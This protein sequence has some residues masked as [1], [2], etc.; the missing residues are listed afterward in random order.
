MKKLL[1]SVIFVM[2][3]VL[4]ALAVET[5]AEENLARLRQNLKV[6][7]NTVDSLSIIYDIFDNLPV[8]EQY[9]MAE[10]IYAMAYRCNDY[11]GILDM[12]RD[13]TR[14]SNDYN[15][16]ALC[17]ERA[18]KVPDSELKKATVS[19]IKIQ[20]SRIAVADSVYNDD[21]K[22][23]K[24]IADLSVEY[25]QIRQ[26]ESN[27]LSRIELLFSICF[28]LRKSAPGTA[29]NDRLIEL[30]GLVERLPDGYEALKNLYYNEC[31]S[32]FM[33]IGRYPQAISL[34]RRFLAHLDNVEK[35]Y[36]SSG[37]TYRNLD[38]YRYRALRRLVS[39]YKNLDSVEVEHYHDIIV[40]LTDADIS[41]HREEDMYHLTEI[42]YYMFKKQ[43]E[44][45][46]P[47]FAESLQIDIVRRNWTILLPLYY[48]AAFTVNDPYHIINSL[49]LWN[50]AVR[51]QISDKT[52][53][54]AR[55][56]QILYDTNQLES[57]N[58][59]LLKYNLE[60]DAKTHRRNV[61]VVSLIALVIVVILLFLWLS[62]RRTHRMNLRLADA[63]KALCTERD[64]LQKAH[65]AMLDAEERS[66]RFNKDKSDFIS[67]I[68]RQVSKPSVE[69]MRYS[70]L[71]IDSLDDRSNK[72]ID[73][74]VSVVELNMRLLRSLVNDLVDSADVGQS[75]LSVVINNFSLTHVVNTA[76]E[77]MRSR[78]APD[79]RLVVSDLSPEVSPL[80]D[81]DPQR[82]EQVILN[83]LIN[84]AKFTTR[85]TIDVSY[86]IDRK[87]NMATVVVTDTGTG[88]PSGKEDA[89]FE[90][91]VKLNTAVKGLGLGLYVSRSVAECLG[92]TLTLDA[93]YRS[94]ARFVF[95]FPI[96]LGD[97][98]A[99]PDS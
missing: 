80:I 38:Y 33:S 13:I 93:G 6:A 52:G 67:S 60:L 69:I 5:R 68:T 27:D 7:D 40:D 24:R 26:D 88:I 66:S 34:C 85:G 58:A 98:P 49:K 96:G 71:I 47:L 22:R 64:S 74:F 44:K 48:E 20:L 42:F 91:F 86:Q 73:K 41:V 11:R 72:H 14:R 59:R 4:S 15:F 57:I 82:V 16:T 77:T 97:Q 18:K 19:Y 43:Y 89:I 2:L 83:L 10:K 9:D 99:S 31:V 75:H 25:K 45:A 39:A 30:E 46:L 32:M 21:E 70:Q 94:G 36:Q 65:A 63:N 90:R 56:L 50:D 92:G 79:V 35:K 95:S 29:L 3:V 17:L 1:L 51:Q 55:K 53:E 23:L 62:Y 12:L 54:T 81:S 61:M 37:R 78:L 28:Y 84:A 76:V 87:K 8:Q